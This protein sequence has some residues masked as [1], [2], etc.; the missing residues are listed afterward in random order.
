MAPEF[1]QHGGDI[2][3]VLRWES[4][5]QTVVAR[6]TSRETEVIQDFPTV[7]F[8]HPPC[9][10]RGPLLPVDEEMTLKA[11][12]LDDDEWSA[13]TVAHFSTPPTR[14]LGDANDD[15]LFDQLDIVQVLQAAKYGTGQPADFGEGDWNEDGV[16]DQEDIVAA[17]QAGDY[18]QLGME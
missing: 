1:S 7:W 2:I 16:F 18:L 15:G 13:M 4:Q 9:S 5:I 6:S 10:L 3:P 12:I 14:I 8:L 11:R 17:L